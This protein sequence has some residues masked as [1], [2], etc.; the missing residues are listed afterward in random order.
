[1]TIEAYTELKTN[2]GIFQLR[3]HSSKSTSCLSLVLGD[4]V[5]N[6]PLVRIH[7]ACLFGETFGSLHCDCNFQLQ[8]SM[9]QIELHGQGVIIYGFEEGRGIGLKQKII[10][11]E[12]Q[13]KYSCDT[14]EAFE[15]M[16]LSKPD[17]RTY[18]TEVK[19]LQSLEINKQ[20]HLVTGNPQKRKV[21]T[22]GG[23][24]IISTIHFSDRTLSKEAQ[25]EKITKE[26]K[27]GYIY[28]S[29]QE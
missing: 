7:S 15:K 2:T 14:V 3:Y 1:M 4:V 27:L 23:F 9:K 12:T 22:D 16:G 24:E 11:M 20:I 29:E 21:L 25:D 13:R 5:N 18:Q 8:N 10:A 28:S 26:Q 17:F 19:A 6:I